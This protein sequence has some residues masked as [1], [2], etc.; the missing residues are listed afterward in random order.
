MLF[1]NFLNADGIRFDLGLSV[2]GSTKT[3][4]YKLFTISPIIPN[5]KLG[6]RWT[7]GK[8][9]FFDW[10]FSVLTQ[11]KL[12]GYLMDRKL[13]MYGIVDPFFEILWNSFVSKMVKKPLK[14][15]TELCPTKFLLGVGTSY[16]FAKNVSIFGEVR[17]GIPYTKT[18]F[19]S[20]LFISALAGF[21]FHPKSLN[22]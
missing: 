7:M 11:F 15:I 16:Q 18:E 20:K 8:N 5:L 3:G 14:E 10:D 17:V 22:Q 13:T 12:G 4:V 9:M 19:E 6:Y 1:L 2:S 21:Q